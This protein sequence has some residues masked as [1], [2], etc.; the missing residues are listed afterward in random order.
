MRTFSK[1]PHT[2]NELPARL[3]PPSGRTWYGIVICGLV[4]LCPLSRGAIPTPT[5]LHYKVTASPSGRY[6]FEVDPT[7]RYGVGPSH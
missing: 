1:V 4:A 2:E 7:E 5:P 6:H 3:D